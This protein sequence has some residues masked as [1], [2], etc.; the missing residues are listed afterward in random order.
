M[1]DAPLNEFLETVHGVRCRLAIKYLQLVENK[2][3]PPAFG[4]DVISDLI[5]VIRARDYDEES[6]RYCHYHPRFQDSSPSELRQPICQPCC[7]PH[8]PRHKQKEDMGQSAHVQK[9][10]D[11]QTV[12]KP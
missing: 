1:R 7:C 10:Q 6:S 8:C 3:S 12:Q 2:Y 11:V 5:L 4:Y 9:A